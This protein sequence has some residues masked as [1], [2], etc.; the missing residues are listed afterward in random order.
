MRHSFL[1]GKFKNLQSRSLDCIWSTIF[2]SATCFKILFTSILSLK[3]QFLVLW[4]CWKWRLSSETGLL[5]PVSRHFQSYTY[6]SGSSTISCYEIANLVK[7]LRE[8]FSLIPF[9]M[10]GKSL[11]TDSLTKIAIDDSEA[12]GPRN[13][14]RMNTSSI[15]SFRHCLSS[16]NC[17]HL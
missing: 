15:F 4:R 16:L 2:S 14:I 6:H 1:P 9:A 10:A 12:W 8:I 5:S 17:S 3:S 7:S 13:P 11:S